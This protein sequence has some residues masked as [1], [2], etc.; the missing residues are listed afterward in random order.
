MGKANNASE[1]LKVKLPDD[2]TEIIVAAGDPIPE[3][4][5]IVGERPL[6]PNPSET[7]VGLAVPGGADVVKSFGT[8]G[9]DDDA[10]LAGMD[11]KAL[12]K[13][14]G[15]MDIQGRSKMSA[16]KLRTEIAAA[17]AAAAASDEKKD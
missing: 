3:G 9:T 16:A 17:R 14:A 12:S 15:D 1:R 4:A 5:E 11:K 13:L 2:G 8:T 10:D 7:T 6:E